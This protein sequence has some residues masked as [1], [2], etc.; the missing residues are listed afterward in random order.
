MT[1]LKGQLRSL[2]RELNLHITTHAVH[3]QTVLLYFLLILVD[4]PNPELAWRFFHGSPI[5]GEFFS[6]ALK[7]RIRVNGNFDDPR[8]TDYDLLLQNIEGLRA[9]KTI[10]M[11]IRRWAFGTLK[12]LVRASVSSVPS[13]R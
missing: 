13:A 6:A 8:L 12:K 2:Q 10:K 1:A 7:D 5:V 3:V 4:Y 11:Y 9:G